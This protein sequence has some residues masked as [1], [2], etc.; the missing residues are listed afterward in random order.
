MHPGRILLYI[1]IYSSKKTIKREKSFMRFTHF[2]IVVWTIVCFLLAYSQC[3]R[4]CSAL[5][6]DKKGYTVTI[7]IRESTK[8]LIKNNQK[9]YGCW[10]FKTPPTFKN[11]RN[12]SLQ[13]IVS[14]HTMI[15]CL[16]RS[17]HSNTWIFISSFLFTLTHVLPHSWWSTSIISWVSLLPPGTPK[18]Q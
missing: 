17:M 18:T 3:S 5:E 7:K 4:A 9:I 16:A 1:T 8:Q 10:S 12:T 2:V 14:I 11:T 15:F 13:V 6:L